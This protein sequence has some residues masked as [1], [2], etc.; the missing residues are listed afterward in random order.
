[1]VVQKLCR[2]EEVGFVGKFCWKADMYMRDGL[3]LCG[4]AAAVFV[5]ELS[6]AVDSGMGSITNMFVKL[7]AQGVFRGASNRK[8]GHYYTQT[9]NN[10]SRKHI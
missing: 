5:N 3:H 2:E 7:E 8:R 10:M 6:A 4:K 9:S 1:M